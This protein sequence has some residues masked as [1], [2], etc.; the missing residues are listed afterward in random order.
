LLVGQ[1][2]NDPRIKPAE[3]EQIVKA[4]QANG[5]PVI[6]AIYPDEGHGFARP[7]N[8]NSFLRWLKPS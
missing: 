5:I 4:M 1:E 7:Q 6:Y 3:S 2:A 8:R